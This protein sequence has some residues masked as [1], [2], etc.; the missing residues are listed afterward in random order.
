MRT[1]T[2]FSLPEPQCNLSFNE[3]ADDG[4]KTAKRAYYKEQKLL[5]K[6][7]DNQTTL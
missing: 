2:F 7:I 6:S 3:G 4:K 5:E 1:R